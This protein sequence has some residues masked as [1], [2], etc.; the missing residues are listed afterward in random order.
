MDGPGEMI[1]RAALRR[2]AGRLPGSAGRLAAEEGGQ[3]G[4]Q[5]APRP[6]SRH[7]SY[8]A[9]MRSHDRVHTQHIARRS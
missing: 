1:H 9:L 5:A 2:K 4:R 6:I 7:A 3:E 8:S